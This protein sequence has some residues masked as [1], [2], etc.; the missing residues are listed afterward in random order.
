LVLV[1]TRKRKRR[2]IDERVVVR[3]YALLAHDAVEEFQGGQKQTDAR[4]SARRSRHEL[5]ADAMLANQA[6]V[7]IVQIVG[8]EPPNCTR[9]ETPRAICF[10]RPRTPLHLADERQQRREIAA[11]RAGRKVLSGAIGE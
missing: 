5:E 3:V 8:D 1:P 6:S 9:F 10:T 11:S 2:V 7:A 4:A